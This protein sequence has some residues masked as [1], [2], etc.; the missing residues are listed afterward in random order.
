MKYLT[1]SEFKTLAETENLTLLKEAQS[2]Y[3]GGFK[4]N[5]NAIYALN[6]A[7]ALVA[8]YN[9]KDIIQYT[10]PLAAFSKSRRKFNKVSL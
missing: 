9:G 1:M 10:K 2:D 4:V 7:S 5:E 3:K 8:F 6:R